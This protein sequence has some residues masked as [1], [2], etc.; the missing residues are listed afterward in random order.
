MN[1]LRVNGSDGKSPS[2]S[3]G[4]RCWPD[5]VSLIHGEVGWGSE[6]LVLFIGLRQM[7]QMTAHFSWAPLALF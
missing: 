3:A 7:L 1:N 6:D 4:L 2:G 5:L